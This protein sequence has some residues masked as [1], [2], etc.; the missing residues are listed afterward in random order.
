MFVASWGMNPPGPVVA[1]PNPMT[2]NLTPTR[3]R[4]EVPRRTRAAGITS[5]GFTM[6]HFEGEW[7]VIVMRPR[8]AMSAF[9]AL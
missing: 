4:A 1:E 2:R 3:P 8:N 6:F 9:L 5:L 7:P